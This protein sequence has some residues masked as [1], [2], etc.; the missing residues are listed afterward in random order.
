MHRH[1]AL[2][3]AGHRCLDGAGIEAELVRLDA[4]EDRGGAGE[5]RERQLASRSPA[6]RSAP[7]LPASRPDLS[8]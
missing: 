6:L 5:G 2:G 7:V 1:D 8:T 3:A 4:G